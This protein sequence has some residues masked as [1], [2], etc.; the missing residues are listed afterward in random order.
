MAAPRFHLHERHH[1]I[2]LRHQVNIAMAN[3]EPAL[4]DAPPAAPEPPFRHTLPE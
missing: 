3:P 2:P 1:P 4:D